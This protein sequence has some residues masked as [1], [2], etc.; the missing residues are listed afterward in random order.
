[1]RLADDMNVL[2]KKTSEREEGL[3]KQVWVRLEEGKGSRSYRKREVNFPSL[4]LEGPIIQ[5]KKQPNRLVDNTIK[6]S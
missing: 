5:S 2:V 1:L 6:T 3:S 4:F